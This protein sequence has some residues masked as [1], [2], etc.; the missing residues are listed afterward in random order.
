MAFTVT[1]G[2]WRSGE[3]CVRQTESP[4]IT[5]LWFMSNGLL[6]PGKPVQVKSPFSG[7]TAQPAGCSH[8]DSQWFE[9]IGQQPG[10]EDHDIKARFDIV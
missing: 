6:L 9:I 2:R 5:K 10:P 8:L 3:S 4:F 7:R 1:A